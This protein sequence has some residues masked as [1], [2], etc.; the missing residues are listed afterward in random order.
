MAEFGLGDNDGAFNKLSLNQKRTLSN[1]TKA[2]NSATD[3]QLSNILSSEQ[4]KQYQ[5][6]REANSK[7]VVEKMKS[8]P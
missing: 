3:T 1:K 5:S 6:I 4:L 7:K 2:I 8:E